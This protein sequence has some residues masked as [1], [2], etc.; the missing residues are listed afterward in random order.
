MSKFDGIL[1]IGGGVIGAFAAYYLK[2]KGFT[3]SLLEKDRFGGG[4][5]HGNCGLIV[6]SHILPLNSPDHL[7][8]GLKWIFKKEAPFLI[9]PRMDPDLLRWLIQFARNSWRNRI[10]VSACGR[11]A[12]LGRANDLYRSLITQERLQFEWT[13][14]GLLHVFCSFA[15]LEKCRSVGDFS[16]GFGI[17]GK[18]LNRDDTVKMEPAIDN[19]IAGAWLCEQSTHL[20]PEALMGEM[21]RLLVQMGVKIAERVEVTGF[22]SDNGR[23]V[24]AI[25]NMGE[26]RAGQFVIA[27]GA[28]TAPLA[29]TLGCRLPIQPGKGYSVTMQRPS[30]SPSVPCILQEAKVVATPWA[31]DL[32]LGGTMEFAGY[33][34]VLTRHRLDALF[35][36]ANRYMKPM[37]LDA[38]KEE[39]CGWRPMTPDGLPII[40]RLPLFENVIIAAGH[41]MEGISM[42]PGTGKLI[43]EM[44]SDE[45]PHI[46]PSPYRIARFLL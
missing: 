37:A 13:T 12:L 28:W 45:K 25:T 20:R 35:A 43:S 34:A 8:K 7:I 30:D 17:N 39:W 46:D 42:G 5:S 10:A 1:V 9:K 31:D 32:R 29:K 2:Q 21:K 3:V 33:D 23:A 44:A 16:A 41:N 24:A 22:R 6:P 18:I 26:Y 15:E 38:I 27:S 14:A 36:A 40:D 11:A 4:A 19:D